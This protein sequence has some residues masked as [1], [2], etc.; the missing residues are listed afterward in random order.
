MDTHGSTIGP[1][2]KGPC[3]CRAP[4]AAGAICLAARVR[5]RRLAPRP[6][7]ATLAPLLTLAMVLINLRRLVE[8]EF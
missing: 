8:K 4:A 1:H 6:H 3:S 5:V 7:Q 2:W